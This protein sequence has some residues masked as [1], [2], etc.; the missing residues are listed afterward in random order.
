MGTLATII[1][2]HNEE[3]NLPHALRSVADVSDEI[4]V[5]DSLSTDR[6]AAVAAE[7]G[8][9]VV[10][11]TFVNQAEQFNWALDNLPVQ[12]EWILRLDADEYLLPELCIE[13]TETLR[14]TPADVT[15]FYIRRRMI[16]LDRWIRYGGYY[17]M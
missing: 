4:F 2:T 5:V 8:C 14:K 13:I 17:P 16:F 7:F 3:A 10:T 1:L 11:R 12:S 15:G 9:H 6:T